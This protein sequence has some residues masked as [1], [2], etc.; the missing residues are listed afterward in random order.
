MEGQKAKL[1]SLI[2]NAVGEANTLVRNALLRRLHVTH[3]RRKATTVHSVF[4]R[5]YPSWKVVMTWMQLIW[6]QFRTAK[7]LTQVQVNQKTTSFKRSG[8][9]RWILTD[10]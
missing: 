10:T 8:R 2:A 9:Y 4:P 1:N 7:M 6:T 5:M 3:V